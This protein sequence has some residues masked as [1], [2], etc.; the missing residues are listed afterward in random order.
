MKSLFVPVDVNFTDDPKILRAGPDAELVYVRSLLLAKRLGGN[1]LIERVHLFRLACDLTAVRCGETDEETIAKTLVT[2][3][4]WVDVDGGWVIA[5]WLK[6]NPSDEEI[7]AG[8]QAERDRKANWRKSQQDTSNRDEVSH[9]TES[10][11]THSRDTVETEQE[12]L[13]VTPK[14]QPSDTEFADW[15]TDYPRKTDRAGAVKAFRARR[16]EGVSLERL[17]AAR[18]NYRLAKIGED[19]RYVKHGKSFL[20]PAGPWSEWEHGDPEPAPQAVI[21]KRLDE[22]LTPQVCRDCANQGRYFKGNVLTECEVHRY[23]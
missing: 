22:P 10:L 4:L 13:M 19:Q 7:E 14:A 8:R 9:G 20:A 1:G 3:G 17:T 18:D 2:E 16:R 11:A 6:H 12:E 5:A 23:A 21:P 15:W